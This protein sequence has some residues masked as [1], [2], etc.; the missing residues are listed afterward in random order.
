MED[1]RVQSMQ[2]DG[3]T[4][5]QKQCTN[6]G[7][8]NVDDGAHLLCW[9]HWKIWYKER[10]DVKDVPEPWHMLD[11]KV[12]Q[13]LLMTNENV[14]SLRSAL[15]NDFP[16]LGN[17]NGQ[18]KYTGYIYVFHMPLS[19]VDGEDMYK[20]GYTTYKNVKKRIAE[21]PGAVLIHHWECAYASY[22]ETIIHLLLQHW[23]CYRYVFYKARAPPNAQKRYVSTWF[24]HPARPVHDAVW[25]A[26]EC[27]DW[28]PPK[29]YS[30]IRNDRVTKEITKS[31]TPYKERY[32]VEQEWFYCPLDYVT[33]V[34]ISVVQMIE[35]NQKNWHKGF[36]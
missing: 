22:A 13:I 23:R 26:D 18:K 33:K 28:L 2:C 16:H 32:A 31:A 12:D 14:T 24:E 15:R 3:Q 11:L 36:Q 25:A 7:V 10:H 17:V 34:C 35:S 4:I 5:A 8:I 21:W 9:A 29:I 1:P 19:D 6:N 30:A 27:P 20:V